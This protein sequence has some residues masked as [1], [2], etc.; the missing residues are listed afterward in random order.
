MYIFSQKAAELL[1]ILHQIKAYIRVEWLLPLSNINQYDTGNELLKIVNQQR[2]DE[3]QHVALVLDR[4]FFLLFT[5]AMPCTA[6][7]FLFPQSS[8]GDSLRLNLSNTTAHMADAKCDLTY[9]P[10]LR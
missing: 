6:L 5:L 7:L 8:I 9:K 1:Q 2:L 4:I 10:M 3:W